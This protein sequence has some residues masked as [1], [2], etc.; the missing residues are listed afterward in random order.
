MGVQGHRGTPTHRVRRW[1]KRGAWPYKLLPYIEQGNLYNNWN[2]TSPIKTFMDPARG[3]TGLAA[4]PYNPSGGWDGIWKAGPVTD[5]AAN[6]LVFGS[7][8]NT[9][10]ANTEPPWNSGNPNDWPRFGY[11]IETLTDG[12]S[13]TI[14]LGIKAMNTGVYNNRG[15]GN[16]TLS[17]GTTR[18][19]DDAPITAAGIWTG[20]FSLMR[21][22]GPD[23]Y[24]GFSS[25][26]RWRGS[27]FG[28][29]QQLFP[30][31]KVHAQ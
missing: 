20:G 23:T 8:M 6:A 12:S 3:G 14:F 26:P 25:H 13:N 31:L 16:F 7:A 9:K 28:G 1:Q 27:D 18:S 15:A 17:N 30:W 10:V 19:K 24:F 5:Y 4:D 21:G 11:R 2:F 22:N 29:L